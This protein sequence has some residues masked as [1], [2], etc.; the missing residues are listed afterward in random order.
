MSALFENRPA[1]TDLMRGEDA[2]PDATLLECLQ[3]PFLLYARARG[4]ASRKEIW[5]FNIGCAVMS[6]ILSG[7]FHRGILAIIPLLWGLACIIPSI[8]LEM[9]RLHDLLLPGWLLVVPYLFDILAIILLANTLMAMIEGD[10]PMGSMI[11]GMFMLLAAVVCQ[12]FIMCWPSRYKTA[13]Y[14]NN[15]ASQWGGQPR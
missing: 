3:R 15:Q 13:Q 14:P 5:V 7:L 11:P 2:M 12:L 1:R 8:A 6:G 9:R 4:R 10:E